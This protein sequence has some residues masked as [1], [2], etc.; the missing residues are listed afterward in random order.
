MSNANGKAYALN[1]ITPMKPW[2]TWILRIPFF[3]LR[4]VTPLQSDLINPSFTEFARRVIFPRRALP[5][6]GKGQKREEVESI[7]VPCMMALG[8][9]DPR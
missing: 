7:T 9:V 8:L 6:I 3:V 4:H 2:K 1:V 5:C